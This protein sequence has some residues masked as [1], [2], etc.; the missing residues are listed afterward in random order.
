VGDT[1]DNYGGVTLACDDDKRIQITF[2]LVT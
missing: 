2:E 1:V